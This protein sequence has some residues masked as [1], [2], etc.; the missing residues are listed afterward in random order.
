[1]LPLRLLL[2]E[3]DRYEETNQGSRSKPFAPSRDRAEG[4]RLLSLCLTAN[5]DG[6]PLRRT[7]FNR[8]ASEHRG[9]PRQR[10]W[11]Y[12]PTMWNDRTRSIVYSQLYLNLA[13]IFSNKSRI[14]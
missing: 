6:L 10:C 8:R 2:N 11:K 13:M 1:M 3:R 14:R 9:Q 7:V 4:R 5:F 12:A